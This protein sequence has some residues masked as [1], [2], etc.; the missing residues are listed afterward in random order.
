M[1]AFGRADHVAGY[2]PRGQLSKPGRVLENGLSRLVMAMKKFRV[3]RAF[4]N[5]VKGQLIELTAMRAQWL[6]PYDVIELVS[7]A[8][9]M[10]APAREMTAPP[11]APDPAPRRGRPP[12]KVE[13]A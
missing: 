13:H 7:E 4:G 6:K 9:P 2:Q 12:R 8:A 5:Y 11:P 1:R 10:P 3:T